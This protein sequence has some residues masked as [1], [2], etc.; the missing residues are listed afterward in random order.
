MNPFKRKDCCDI[1][2]KK[3]VVVL[4]YSTDLNFDM[5]TV[6]IDNEK[7]HIFLID[8]EKYLSAKGRCGKESLK[9]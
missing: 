7:Y 2:R 3:C 4:A 6:N 5:N 9:L 1:K 8:R